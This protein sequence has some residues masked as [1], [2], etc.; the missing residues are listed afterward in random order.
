[1]VAY[2]VEKGLAS[3]D[4]VRG[5]VP[6]RKIPLVKITAKGIDYYDG[7][8]PAD[9]GAYLEPRGEG[10]HQFSVVSFQSKVNS[11]KVKKSKVE[12]SNGSSTSR[13]RLSTFDFQLLTS[14][15]SDH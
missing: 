10:S 3:V 5:P 8:L 9:S 4:E 7:R 6:R 12:K 13:L 14:D 11:R 15:S 2:L 1:H